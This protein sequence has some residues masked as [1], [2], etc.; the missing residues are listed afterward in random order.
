[1]ELMAQTAF[2]TSLNNSQPSA[3]QHGQPLAVSQ[4]LIISSLLVAL[5]VELPSTMHLLAVAVVDRFSRE[6]F[7]VELHRRTPSRWA[8]A[9]LLLLPA[10]LQE[11]T[12][13]HRQ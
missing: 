1:M 13:E 2:V 3:H 7:L 4:V 6:Q 12:A 8:E 5:Q 10:L 11:A 9:A